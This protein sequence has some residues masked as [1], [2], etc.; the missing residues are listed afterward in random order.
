MHHPRLKFLLLLW[1][2]LPAL[3]WA[4]PDDRRQPI[5]LEADSAELDQKTGISIYQGNVVI[6]QGSMRMVAD[7]ATIYFK[8]GRF[9]RIEAVG[10]PV[11]LR[12]KPSVDK[13]EIQGTGQRVVYNAVTAKV[14]MTQNAKIVQGQDSFTG[15]RIEYD[16]EKD[17][18]KANSDKGKRIQFIIQPQTIQDGQR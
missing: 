13:P 6:S 5:R 3:A 11:D 2:L 15:D 7:T 16:L 10:K 9:E 4:L 14:V 8:D 1:F 17:Q 18:V 12:Y